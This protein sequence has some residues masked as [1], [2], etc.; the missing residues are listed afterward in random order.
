MGY[1]I[2]LYRE[3]EI[4]LAWESG[5]LKPVLGAVWAMEGYCTGSLEYFC[6]GSVGNGSLFLG[7]VWICHRV[8][9]GSGR[10]A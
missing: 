2:L 9:Q 5:V 1:G 8:N 6:S 4:L 7:D 3:S 10:L